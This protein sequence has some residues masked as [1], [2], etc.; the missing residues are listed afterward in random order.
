MDDDVNLLD[1]LEEKEF[2]LDAYRKSYSK[3][4][5][6]A[7]ISAI[8]IYIA[9]IYIVYIEDDIEEVAS[10]A[11]GLV[12]LFLLIPLTSSLIGAFLT[13]I[14]K[15]ETSFIERFKKF[16]WLVSFWLHCVLAFLSLLIAFI[17]TIDN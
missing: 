14:S 11:V 12:F 4:K 7:I 16:F 17:L 1:D 8:G 2:D 13:S 5:L 6:V 10:F 15:K 9:W 3:Y